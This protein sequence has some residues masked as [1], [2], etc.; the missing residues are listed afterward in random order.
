MFLV[1]CLMLT[2]LF[3]MFIMQAQAQAPCAVPNPNATAW[4]TSTGPN[5][6]GVD[7][8]PSVNCSLPAGGLNGAFSAVYAYITTKITK[9]IICPLMGYTCLAPSG[10]DDSPQIQ[11]AMNAAGQGKPPIMFTAGLYAPC[12]QMNITHD[13]TTL[14]GPAP[15]NVDAGAGGAGG[16]AYIVRI[17]PTSCSSGSTWASGQDIF[18]VNAEHVTIKDLGFYGFASSKNVNCIHSIVGGNYFIYDSFNSCY[19]AVYLEATVSGSNCCG[20]SYNQ[21][22]HV[23]NNVIIFPE[24]AGILCQVTTGSGCTDNFFNFNHIDDPF[25]NSIYCGAGCGYSQI[26][27]NRAEDGHAGIWLIPAAPTNMEVLVNDNHMQ[28]LGYPLHLSNAGM[29]TIVGNT[30][31]CTFSVPAMQFTGGNFSII[32]IGNKSSTCSAAYSVDAGSTVFSTSLFSNTQAFLSIFNDWFD[33][34][35]GPT[36]YD[37]GYTASQIEPYYNGPRNARSGMQYHVIAPSG[38]T[39]TPFPDG[40]TQDIEFDFVANS[41]IADFADGHV[42]G[43]IGTFKIKQDATGGRTTTWDSTYLNQPSLSGL[44]ASTC[45][46]VPYI[47]TATKTL[48]Q[49]AIQN[50]SCS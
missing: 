47:M 42:V 25:N 24:D 33:N 20:T 16:I 41:T 5:F 22:S 29:V 50:V 40:N 45:T 37:T 18:H 46:Y 49:T 21:D 10:G 39:F 13:G 1:R 31:N 36:P 7:S 38:T 8:T 43:R 15:T 48:L 23:E 19:D 12:S 44:T 26:I 6:Q 35:L 9:A 32:S 27:G 28:A 3:T 17:D 14:I 2:F 30:I 34:F 4:T 11:A